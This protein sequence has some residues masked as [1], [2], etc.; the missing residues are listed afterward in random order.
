MR[1]KRMKTIISKARETAMNCGL[2]INII[3]YDEKFHRL[4]ENYTSI[5]VKL[6]QIHKLA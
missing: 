2:K 1:Y 3:I 4:K 5:D 6:E